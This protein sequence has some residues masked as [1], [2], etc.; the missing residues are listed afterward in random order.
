[1]G[2]GRQDAFIVR[3]PQDKLGVSPGAPTPTT[4]SPVTPAPTTPAPT[5]SRADD[6]GTHSGTDD[7]G[8]DGSGS[9]QRDLDEP[10]ERRRRAA[11]R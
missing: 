7:P 11:R 8:A 6:A 9:G 3:I 10:D 2:T 4:P 5:D 1:M